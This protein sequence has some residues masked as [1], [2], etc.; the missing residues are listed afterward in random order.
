MTYAI[1]K[2]E[3]CGDETP[4][5]EMTFDDDIREHVCAE[6]AEGLALAKNELVGQNITPIH[7]GP[8]CG[9]SNG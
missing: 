9:N 7:R 5:E 2:C 1:L 4:S 6:C 8:F 3:C